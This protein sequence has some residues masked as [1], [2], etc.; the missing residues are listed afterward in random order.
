MPAR[1]DAVR[2]D[3]VRLG[4]AED[5]VRECDAAVVVARGRPADAVVL[6]VLES[7]VARVLVEHADEDDIARAITLVHA[8]ERGVLLLTGHAPGREEIDDRDLPI[9]RRI[10]ERA[11]AV[12][13]LEGE[14]R[15]GL[16]DGPGA[17]VL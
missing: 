5:A 1:N 10:R 14:R 12:E 17:Q 6:H 7:A 11:A 15:G 4:D 13:L 2:P 16:A 3:E 8:H 9:G